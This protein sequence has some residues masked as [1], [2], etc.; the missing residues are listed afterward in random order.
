M[1]EAFRSKP[2]GRG[3]SNR[4]GVIGIFLWPNP[5]GRTVATWSASL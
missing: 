4:K 1:S 3:F 5:S 2:E